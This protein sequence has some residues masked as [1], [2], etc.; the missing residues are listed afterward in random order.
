MPAVCLWQQPPPG[1]GK[2]LFT[3][4]ADEA[5]AEP[6]AGPVGAAGVLQVCAG[7][8]RLAVEVLIHSS[9][10]PRLEQAGWRRA[11]PQS[12]RIFL[13]L[14]W[15]AVGG[16]VDLQLISRVAGCELAFPLPP[17]PGYRRPASSPPHADARRA[18]QGRHK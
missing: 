4:M 8:R 5:A 15:D 16:G 10:T 18:A 7:P 13:F 9:K 2:T 1:G 11:S 6:P 14:L 12:R 17:P 3:L